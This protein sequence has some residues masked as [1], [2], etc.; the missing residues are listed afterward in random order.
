MN[1]HLSLADLSPQRQTTTVFTSGN[2]QAVRL[3]KAFRFNAKT[4]EI[5]RRGDEIVLREQPQSLGQRLAE[6]MA[7]LP[8]LSDKDTASLDLALSQSRDRRPAQPRDWSQL[9]E[10]AAMPA[11]PRGRRAR[12]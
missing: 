12:T 10:E 9:L 11:T 1:K 6:V 7:D 8:A 3:P 2:S 5:S 4:V